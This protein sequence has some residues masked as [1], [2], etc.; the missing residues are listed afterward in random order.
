MLVQSETIKPVTD[1]S[2]ECLQD[3]N[4]ILDGDISS[5]IL[6]LIKHNRDPVVRAR[7]QMLYE[8]KE[9]RLLGINS[10]ENCDDNVKNALEMIF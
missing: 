3:F 10:L 1:Y 5:I 7:K 9:L 2:E 4:T 6:K 8:K